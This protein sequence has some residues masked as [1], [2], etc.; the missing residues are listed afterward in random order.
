MNLLKELL[1][2]EFYS[3]KPLE[4]GGTSIAGDAAPAIR[5]L[6]GKAIKD[7]DTV[8]DYGAGKYAR[9]ADFFR[10]KGIKAFAFDP[11][12]SNATEKEGWDEGKVAD[13]VS[14][15]TNGGKKF[16][17]AFTCFV[18]NVVPKNVEAEIIAKSEKLGKK[19]VHI[20]R[21]MDVFDMVKSAMLKKDKYVYPFYVKEYNKGKDV[22]PKKLTDEDIMEFCKFGVQTSRGF[23]RI[24]DLESYGYKLVRN[25]S[26][27]KIYEK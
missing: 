8:L 9:N 13:A 11:F 25:T 23:Q 14:L 20:T 12:N 24:P 19:T 27:F 7:G 5:A 3:G 4:K 17:V 26:G 15:K 22:D 18:L 1:E 6:Y 2:A 10:K 16:S 21:N